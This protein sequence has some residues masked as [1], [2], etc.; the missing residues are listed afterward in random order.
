MNKSAARPFRRVAIALL[1][2]A[3][4]LSA[5]ASEEAGEATAPA[6]QEITT[7][8]IP[9]TLNQEIAALVPGTIAEAGKITVASGPGYPPFYLLADDEK[10]LVGADVEQ[11]RA[12]GDVLGLEISFQD[13]KFDAMIP[14]LQTNRVDMAAGAFSVT[15]E[16][17]KAVDFV[18]NFA[19]G[20]SLIVPV[21]NPKDVGLDTM[22]G[23]KIAVQKAPSTRTTTC[24]SS[25]RT[26]PTPVRKPSTSQS[27]RPRR[28]R[29]SPSPPA[30]PTP[31][32]PTTARWSTRP[33]APTGSS[34]C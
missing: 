18:S 30:A 24:R 28:T 8:S 5:C 32:C 17:L 10:T 13:I 1:G 19:G 9:G 12:I 14:A 22:C 25:T 34:R 27:S 4:L 21:G 11:V 26:A 33:S 29:F 23:H 6:A 16:R 2:T 31:T 7:D 15:E 3:T 20:T